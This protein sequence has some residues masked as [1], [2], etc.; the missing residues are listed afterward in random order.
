[1]SLT[2]FESGS[3]GR[4][5]VPIRLAI[6]VL[7]AS[8]LWWSVLFVIVPV[9]VLA[10]SLWIDSQF[11]SG[12]VGICGFLALVLWSVSYYQYG[13][14]RVE[15][16]P[17]ARRLTLVHRR[18]TSGGRREQ[19]VDLRRVESVS[20]RVLGSTALVRIEGHSLGWRERFVLS[21]PFPVPRTEVSAALETL[22][23][24]GVTVPETLPDDETYGDT[25]TFVRL[26]VTPLTLVGVPSYAAVAFGPS[27]FVTNGAVI[28]L[29]LCL[30]A[31]SRELRDET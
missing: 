10:G 7:S 9:G 13:R 4:R 12:I 1:M 14:P 28:V 24:A 19:T 8:R 22:R 17:A 16:D 30:V 26:V 2:T 23:T 20:V 21:D 18:G 11:A 15:I 29:V 6:A 27:V 25:W 31:F 3:D 5:R